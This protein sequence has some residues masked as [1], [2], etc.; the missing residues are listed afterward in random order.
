MKPI[1]DH[2]KAVN[3]IIDLITKMIDSQTMCRAATQALSI[4]TAPSEGNSH[5]YTHFNN[6]HAFF[7][8]L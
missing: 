6:T 4:I 3:L 8:N 1:K 2:N 7:F 5:I